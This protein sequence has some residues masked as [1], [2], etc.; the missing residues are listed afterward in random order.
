M[1]HVVYTRS[2]DGKARLYL[3]GEK[4]A[5]KDIEGSTGNWNGSYKLAL[6]N[7]F[8]SGRLWKG[9]YDL[10][11]IYG[12]DL[13]PKEVARNFKAGS[14]AVAP[15][16]VT[17][18]AK[19][20]PNE[21]LFETKIASILSK[22]CLECH[23]SSNRKG[24]LDLSRKEAALA[25]GRD[26]PPI[27]P[28]KIHESLLW[29]TVSTDEMPEDRPPLSDAEKAL[30]KKWIEGGAKWS[31][32]FI[33]P[34]VYAHEGEDRGIWIRRLTIPEYIE[35]VRA[36]TGVDISW[37]A[38][39]LLPKDLRAD[40]FSN[41]AY[42][43]NVDL[44]HVESYAKLAEV[45]V[46]RM[47]V[48]P[49][50]K[51]FNKSEK[52]TDN[53]MG[54]LISRMGKWLLRGPV[55][56]QEIIAYRGISTTVASAGG[57]FEE[58]VGLIIEGMLQSPRFIYQ[59]ENQRGD[60]SKWPADDYELASRLSYMLWGGPPDEALFKAAEEGMLDR[61]GIEE[62]TARMLKDPRAITKSQQFISEWLNLGRL[63]NMTPNKDRFP[64]WTRELANDMRDETM[65]YFKEVVWEQNRPLADLLNA[66]VTFATPRLAKHYGIDPKSDREE[67]ERYEL[68]SVPSRGGL[69]TQGSVLTIGGDDASTV[70]RGLFVLH[71]LLRGVV[72][73]PPPGTD[74]TPVP[75]RPGQTNRT[76]AEKRI[77]D[78][79]CGGCHARFEPLSFG[80]EKFNG[81]G[82]Y[83]ER[84]EH[85]NELRE[86]GEVLFPGTAKPVAYKTSAELMD[87]LAENDRVRESLTWKV[88][89]FALG[90]PLG[91]SD[92]ATVT[93]IHKTAQANGGTYQALMKA[94]VTSDLV[95]MTPTETHS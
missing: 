5:S 39:E 26:G 65:A 88:T 85:G 75:T 9:T 13:S 57:N 27:V 93:K 16:V 12:R 87:I 46:S 84:D 53:D 68:T 14:D 70:T 77:A 37:E 42:N 3:N 89:Q 10:V 43:L 45:I 56:D 28:G 17:E 7:E 6:G 11:A 31:L 18:V 83:Q 33:D 94:I 35:T 71:D 64:A 72:K 44:K 52:F 67:L 90:R 74:T 29:E 2:R 32:D 81:V 79:S 86:D 21:H 95:L 63:S 41:T 51:R 20:D 34:A 30:L 8:G 76:V 54:K 19:V 23:D 73:D 50:A 25:G 59:V 4:T 61:Q 62:Q 82:A 58:A 92:A 22:H 15:A 78:R 80:L 69:L 24:K 36:A 48:L 60:G 66:Q 49:F 38:H 55:E 91:A 1:T 47:E 40:G